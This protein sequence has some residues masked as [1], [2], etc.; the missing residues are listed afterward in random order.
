[1][2]FTPSHVAAVLPARWLG[3]PLSGL[4]VGSMAPDIP[5]FLPVSG[6]GDMLGGTHDIAGLVGIDLVL[7]LVA[8]TVWQGLLAAPAA[9]MAPRWVRARLPEDWPPGLLRSLS[10]PASVVRLVVALVLGAATHVAWDGF[11]H[12]N[13]WGTGRFALLQVE[14]IE[15]YPGS[16]VLQYVSGAG[17]LVVL[18]V[19]VA[20]W[21]WSTPPRAIPEARS[22]W[23]LGVP[24]VLVAGGA[25]ALAGLVTLRAGQGVR[26]SVFEAVVS[27]GAAGGIACVT[28]AVAWRLT[29]AV[30]RPGGS[31]AG[32]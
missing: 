1:M 27:A 24:P 21:A 23:W 10:G 11:T 15:G 22:A 8:W 30:T 18:A 4:A 5:Y 9:A 29:P 16:R 13:A 32:R 3:L 19:A 31:P 7:G 12:P 17:G 14:V 6:V 2:P 25:G 20:W 26:R 28:V